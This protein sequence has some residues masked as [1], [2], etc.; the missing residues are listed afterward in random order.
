MLVGEALLDLYSI[1]GLAFPSYAKLS[2][3]VRRSVRTV[4]RAL[5]ELQAAGLLRW[6][7]RR[8][9]P[10]VYA[11]AFSVVE[12]AWAHLVGSAY[13]D[14]SYAFAGGHIVARSASAGPLFEPPKPETPLPKLSAE[15][16]RKYFAK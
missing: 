13:N 6:R 7:R 5:H 8:R 14:G 10:N 12:A 3:L 15:A 9:W 16:L 2:K 1:Q 4:G 11:F